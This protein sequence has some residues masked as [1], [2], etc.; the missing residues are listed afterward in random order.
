MK[1]LELINT[2]SFMCIIFSFL[3]F[4]RNLCEIR[5]MRLCFPPSQNYEAIFF[6]LEF[7]MMID[8]L[9][10]LGSNLLTVYP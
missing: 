9:T 1:A 7:S 6:S 2:S 5:D 3:K 8:L 10:W 4:I